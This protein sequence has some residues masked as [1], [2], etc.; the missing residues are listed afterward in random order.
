[1]SAGTV[2]L[3]STS[4]TDLL[5]ARASGAATGWATR[6][7]SPWTICRAGRGTALVVVRLLGG[8]RAWEDGLDALLAGPRPV[9][10][11]GGE[12]APTRN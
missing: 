5:S 8:R 7:G 6:R 12:Q 2:L 1:M 10:V 9:V 4:D 3:L 11:L